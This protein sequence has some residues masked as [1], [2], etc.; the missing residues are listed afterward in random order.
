MNQQEMQAKEKQELDQNRERTR[1]GRTY[2]PDTDIRETPDSLIVTTEMPGVG[3][4]HID[5]RLEKNVLTV[6]GQVDFTQ[7][8]GLTPVYTEYNVGNYV[9]SFTVSNAVD[10]SG[11]TASMENGVLRVVLPK[12]KEAEARQIKVQ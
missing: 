1:A 12:H 9:R 7:Y 3:R 4:D 5:V 2:L 8:E 11:I 6:S 10:Q